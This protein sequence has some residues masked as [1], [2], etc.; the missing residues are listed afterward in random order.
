M[1]LNLKATH[2]FSLALIN[3]FLAT[4]IILLFMLNVGLVQEDCSPTGLKVW[5]WRDLGLCS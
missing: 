1:F 2:I 5:I 4:T 3:I